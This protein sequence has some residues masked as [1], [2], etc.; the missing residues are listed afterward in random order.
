MMAGAM[1]LAGCGGPETGQTEGDVV[2]G[3]VGD[4]PPYF[5]SLAHFGSTSPFCGGT[6]IEDDI[7][8]TAAHCVRGDRTFLRVMFP[9]GSRDRSYRWRSRSVQA[10]VVH[11]DFRVAEDAAKDVALLLL[12]RPAPSRSDGRKVSTIWRAGSTPTSGELTIMGY[13]NATNFGWL[14]ADAFQTATAS[15]LSPCPI[16]GALCLS[17]EGSAAATSN[18]DSGGPVVRRRLTGHRLVGVVSGS[19]DDFGFYA[20]V[21]D[22]EDWIDA[23][24][25]LLRKSIA[26]AGIEELAPTMVAYCYDHPF[27]IQESDDEGW[28][29]TRIDDTALTQQ[30]V[31]V[32][33]ATHDAPHEELMNGAWVE[34]E[35]CSMRLADETFIHRAI[36]LHPALQLVRLRAYISPREG[37][38]R[39]FELLAKAMMTPSI[40][41][42]AAD[43]SRLSLNMASPSGWY[44]EPS[45]VTFQVQPQ[46][47][48]MPAPAPSSWHA[49]FQVGE[50]ELRLHE[51][52][53]QSYAWW[54][55]PL[56]GAVEAPVAMVDASR[57]ESG[58]IAV[59][60]WLDG[61][62]VGVEVDNAR[63]EEL[64]AWELACRSGSLD[65]ALTFGP[66]L[67]ETHPEAA[68]ISAGSS[69]QVVS[70]IALAGAL[71]ADL[72][73]EL[74]GIEVPLELR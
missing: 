46:G 49:A 7:V 72:T 8:L 10:M 26:T 63:A 12:D 25:G 59:A 36:A 62:H 19:S 18:G 66:Y 1:L 65:D 44:V 38:K 70:D 33:R 27:Y 22:L 39:Y 37:E 50:T 41:A 47:D 4:P 15:V 45:G 17:R 67:P 29:R 71:P 57:A 61:G 14:R 53:G 68:R 28:A 35:G 23:Q 3:K 56:L 58:G 51:R 52:D 13:G 16:D 30:L 55:S 73:C 6:L 9:S 34:G 69:V 48:L 11:E 24:I 74:N 42:T 32:D 31:E 21:A 2:D 54:S 64:V 60:L 43:Q 20:P 5:V 40:G